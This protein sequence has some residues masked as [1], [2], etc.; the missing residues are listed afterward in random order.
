MAKSKSVEWKEKHLLIIEDTTTAS[1]GLF[2]F[3]FAV[4]WA[5]SQRK[6]PKQA[7]ICIVPLFWMHRIYPAMAWVSS[8]FVLLQA[9]T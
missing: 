2:P 5:L 1:F 7:L 3:S 9:F 8:W 4:V 6:A